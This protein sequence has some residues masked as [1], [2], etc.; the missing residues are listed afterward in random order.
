QM[1]YGPKQIDGYGYQCDKSSGEM[2]TELQSLDPYG[3]NKS[4]HYPRNG[5]M[6]FRQQGVVNHWY[7]FSK[8]DEPSKRCAQ[9]SVPQCR[10]YN[11][12]IKLLTAKNTT[13]INLLVRCTQ[14]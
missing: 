9:H 8:D 1:Q 4:Q 13:L 12:V 2:H 11:V 10:T 14:V 7:L 5:L 6:Q 3:H